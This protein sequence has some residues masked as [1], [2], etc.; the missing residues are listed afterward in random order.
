MTPDLSMTY[1][2]LR[3]LNIRR[4]KAAMDWYRAMRARYRG[5]MTAEDVDEAEAKLMELDAEL[6]RA[7]GKRHSSTCR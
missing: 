3:D 7:M 2:E 6:R 1:E 4:G 5:E